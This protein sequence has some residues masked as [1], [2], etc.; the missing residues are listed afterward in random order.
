MQLQQ[1]SKLDL[2]LNL[3]SLERTL[4]PQLDP[5]HALSPLLPIHQSH[6]LSLNLISQTYFVYLN[7]VNSPQ[8]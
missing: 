3:L 5:V 6:P 7:H 1:L 4:N 2:N 8:I